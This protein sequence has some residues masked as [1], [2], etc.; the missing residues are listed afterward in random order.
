MTSILNFLVDDVLLEDQMK[1]KRIRR[2]VASNTITDGEL[3]RK[4]YSF[5]L[6][7]CLDKT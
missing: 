3:F 6:L 2:Q 1:A 5:P 7:K 4:G